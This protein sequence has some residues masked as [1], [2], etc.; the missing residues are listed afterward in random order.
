MT[1]QLTDW[2]I[3]WLTDWLP[4]WL[5]SWLADWLTDW[6]ANWLADCLTS[7]LTDWLAGWLTDW[8]A[9]WLAGWQNDWLTNWVNGYL[10]SRLWVSFTCNKSVMLGIKKHT[11]D[12]LLSRPN[13]IVCKYL[14]RRNTQRNMYFRL[15]T[16]AGQI[17]YCEFP[18]GVE[19]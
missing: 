6:L 16:S 15:D 13:F 1:D 2:L 5:T 18:W 11:G 3:S 12:A 17:I 19:H 4:K 8:L 7:S 9:D 10:T 14:I